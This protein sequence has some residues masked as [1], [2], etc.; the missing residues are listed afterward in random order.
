VTS[1]N[2]DRHLA[3]ARWNRH[4]VSI[5]MVGAWRDPQPASK[6]SMTIMRPPQQGHGVAIT[7]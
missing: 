1:A 5:L 6:V 3:V 2:G 4:D 7:D